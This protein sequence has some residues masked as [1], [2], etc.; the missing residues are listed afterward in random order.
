MSAGA[1]RYSV[2]IRDP[3]LQQLLES[4]GNRSEVLREGI[5]E[6]LNGGEAKTMSGLSESEMTGYE[7]LKAQEG[8]VSID[9]AETAMAVKTQLDKRIVRRSV[10]KSLARLGL[11][12]IDQ[13]LWGVD[14]VAIP[15]IECAF[16]EADV[17][18]EKVT[19]HV[20]SNHSAGGGQ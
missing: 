8:R 14:L 10:V 16:C 15:P 20:K 3:E 7:W 5:R 19:E 17:P 4:S 2:E 6:I 11:V 18:P 1:K 9:E 13:Q 12:D